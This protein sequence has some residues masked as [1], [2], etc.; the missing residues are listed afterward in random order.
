MIIRL[1]AHLGGSLALNTSLL[2]AMRVFGA[3]TGLLYW[4]I[5]ARVMPAA[6]VGLASGAISAASL[7][8]GFAQLG[9]GYGLVRH[10]PDSD[11]SAGMINQ[12]LLLTATAGMLFGALFLVLLPLWSP[13]LLP[14]RVGG[15]AVGLFITL[16]VSTAVTQQL[17]W[18]FLAV[19]RLSFSLWKMALQSVLALA[20][21]VALAV[22]LPG[23]TAN[24]AAYTLSTILALWVCFQPLLP[25]AQPGY[26]PVLR[27]KRRLR[28]SFAGYS[29]G[30]F[31]ADQ[32]QRVPDTLLPLIVIQQLGAASGAYFFVVWTL[33]RGMTA[34]VNSAAE[35]LFAAGARDSTRA[36]G[37]TWRAIR[38]SL[39]LG[40]G[41]VAGT[42]LFGRL[43][44]SIY[45]PAYIEQGFTLLNLIALASIPGALLF[46]LV[47]LLRLRSRMRAVSIIMALSA[48]AG[49]LSSVALVPAGLAAVGAGW[50]A[51]QTAVLL[52]TAGWMALERRRDGLR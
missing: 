17:H 12:S 4:A 51:A 35:A 43:V 13:E 42:A 1:K 36:A 11:D 29:L 33:G 18:V 14:L 32:F 27:W 2:V 23:F 22:A 48:G 20:L 21:L 7:V 40:G 5:A 44:L 16:T 47:S 19:D 46:T 45:G 50:L 3:V 28:W 30:N 10:L 49:M 15:V 34:W 31:F 6:A 37:H 39:L 24:V 8:A 25:L 41:L 52:A 9:L 38:L 26:R